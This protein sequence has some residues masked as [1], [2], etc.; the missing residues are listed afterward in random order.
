MYKQTITPTTIHH[1]LR[2]AGASSA[3]MYC[4]Q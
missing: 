1:G 4:S 2:V 3:E